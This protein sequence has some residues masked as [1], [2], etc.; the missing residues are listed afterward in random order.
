MTNVSSK[1]WIIL[2]LNLLLLLT[3]I[4]GDSYLIYFLGIG[5][6]GIVFFS[7][8]FQTHKLSQAQLLAVSILSLLLLTIGLATIFSHS[9]PLSISNG[10]FWLYGIV[11]FWLVVRLNFDTNEKAF[12]T[13]LLLLN[14][15]T[16]SFLNVLM[17]L[18]PSWA[19]QL[20]G[21]NLFF[22]SYGHSHLA[23]YL[24][25]VVPVSW[26]IVMAK[27][28]F[29]VR[30]P[31][32]TTVFL[33]A[34]LLISFS[35]T[36]VVI[37]FGQ[38]LCIWWY[39]RRS[40][41]FQ[42]R[43]QRKKIRIFFLLYGLV[44]TL[45]IAIKIGLGLFTNLA[46]C[47]FPQ[48]A[49]QLCKSFAEE[50]RPL[51]WQQAWQAI[52]EFPVFGYG[53]GTFS[54]ISQR[55]TQTPFYYTGYAHNLFLQVF[56]E[57]G[58]IVGTV[59]LVFWVVVFYQVKVV[60]IRKKDFSIR[61][62]MAIGLTSLFL[63]GL[64]DF[65]W[66]F[67]G[68]LVAG[69]VIIAV[70]FSGKPNQSPYLSKIFGVVFGIFT[71][72]LLVICSLF[73]L[74]DTLLRLQ[75][76]QL[77]FQ[78][79]PAFSAHQLIYQQ[80]HQQLDQQQQQQLEDIYRYHDRFWTQNVHNSSFECPSV[81][82]FVQLHPWSIIDRLDQQSQLIQDCDWSVE[83]LEKIV[84]KITQAEQQYGYYPLGYTTKK[85]LAKRLTDSGLAK[86]HT[87]H[88]IEHF[89]GACRLA[90]EFEPWVFAETLVRPLDSDFSSSDL[91]QLEQFYQTIP[92]EYRG[93]LIWQMT[94]MQQVLAND[95]IEHRQYDQAEAYLQQ[96]RE[97]LPEEFFQT[98]QLANF[99]LLTGDTQ[100]AEAAYR[101]CERDY[102]NEHD[103][104][105]ARG[106]GDQDL[107]W[108]FGEE[109]L[110]QDWEQ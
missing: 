106:W 101:Q 99:Y 41:A 13:K 34:M 25:L 58:V 24:L 28:K 38:L 31:V 14:G 12:V 63:S 108:E 7:R 46:N 81:H 75:K 18:F 27:D 78:V 103:A 15:L 48:Y 86:F 90:Y 92:S 94:K 19:S 93:N 39:S 20:P 2:I 104:C 55:F 42:K 71:A 9:L 62:A 8:K 44:I 54:L 65:D 88:N 47:P 22:A 85:L 74:T 57:S 59:W 29:Q 61:H 60:F 98:S 43:S 95:A 72:V 37:A 17:L 73:S 96:M 40:K 6:V 10:V 1:F 16:L 66:S 3:L 33:L 4:L 100:Q 69:L 109:L 76:Y 53:P 89:I 50:S 107:Y 91:K 110:Q 5:L 79:M 77:A 102:P 70:L 82:Q 80:E 105:Q 23:A 52:Q 68:I 36:G 56:A 35:R 21:M 97:L 30:L 83:E 87:D 11:F 32:L 45:V 64:V 84:I 51:Y 26:W 49:N 67:Q